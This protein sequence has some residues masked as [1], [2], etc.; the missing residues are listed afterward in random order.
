[1]PTNSPA[2]PLVKNFQ[3]TCLP[4]PALP[5]NQ[6]PSPFTL[7]RNHHVIISTH[8]ANRGTKLDFTLEWPQFATR[9]RICHATVSPCFNRK[10][11]IIQAL[12]QKC[13]AC[14]DKIGLEFHWGAKYWRPRCKHFLVHFQ[15]TTRKNSGDGSKTMEHKRLPHARLRLAS[16]F[17]LER[18]WFEEISFLG[19]DTWIAIRI[20]DPS[21]YRENSD[22]AWEIH[23]S[24]KSR[25][26]KNTI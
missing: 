6:H 8:E 2:Q 11:Y 26:S 10:N 12:E 20:Y 7:H 23:L 4:L 18:S 1:M 22:E 16:M 19:S 24:R 5:N 17:K 13:S 15:N 3:E 9:N 25:A 14:N 21:E